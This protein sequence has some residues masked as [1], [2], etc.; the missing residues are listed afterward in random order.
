MHEARSP[1]DLGDTEPRAIR[2]TLR[3]FDR[4]ADMKAD[5]YRYWHSR[6][7]HERLR[8]RPKSTASDCGSG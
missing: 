3:H 4:H 5:E 1:A 2:G 8:K 7:V 6:P